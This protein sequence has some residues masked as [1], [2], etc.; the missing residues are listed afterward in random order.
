MLVL[1]AVLILLSLF[2]VYRYS[3]TSKSCTAVGQ[4]PPTHMQLGQMPITNTIRQS[5]P[6]VHPHAAAATLGYS[7]PPR[8]ILDL[9]A[10]RSTWAA[11]AGAE[12]RA[13]ARPRST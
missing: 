1:F 6:I 9:K 4:P 10:A 11:P 12:P 5:I 3:H 13:L 2:W 7:L 8:A